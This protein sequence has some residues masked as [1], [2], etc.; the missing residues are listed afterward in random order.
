ML[1][2]IGSH[3]LSVRAPHLLSRPPK[4]WDF[5]GTFEDVNAALTKNRDQFASVLPKGSAKMIARVAG[6][7]LPY[8]FELAWSGTAG[9][10]LLQLLRTDVDT[11]YEEVPAVP[12]LVAVPSVDVL[13]ALK[14]SHR[15]LK[16][17]PHFL[18][19][20]RDIQ[21]M[22]AAGARVPDRYKDWFARREKETYSYG[23]P[24]L[25]QS[26][27]G[28]FSGDGVQYMYDHDTIHLAMAVHE[29]PAYTYFQK[30]GAQVAVD[31]KK[32]D[33]LPL[34]YQLA[35][36]LEE[37][38]VLALERSQIPFGCKLSPRQSFEIALMKVCTSIT[39]GWWRE[40][41][42]EHYDAALARY[43]DAYVDRFWAAVRA[44]VVKK[45]AP[46]EAA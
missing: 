32:W 37:S 14:L 21:T 39:S 9:A 35:S 13:Y 36:V 22:R 44:G 30:D 38:Y 16:N 5:V 1:A 12:G 10:E 2:L 33:A 20:M 41:A 11:T 8:E 43:D 40:F 23:H 27:A 28:F 3:A 26:K 34:E 42:W 29:K 19:T 25:N 24:N 4:D 15:Y 46:P 18:K 6:T 45:L 31:R 7:G 17:S